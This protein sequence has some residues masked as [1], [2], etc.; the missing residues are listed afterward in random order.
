MFSPHYPSTSATQRLASALLSVAIS[1]DIERQ[2][3]K[4][5]FYEENI[6]GGFLIYISDLGAQVRSTREDGCRGC[7]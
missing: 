4:P 2:N 3:V 1:V 6:L 7:C 5:R